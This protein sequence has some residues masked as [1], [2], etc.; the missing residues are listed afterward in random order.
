MIVISDKFRVVVLNKQGNEER[1][2]LRINENDITTNTYI[3]I[4][5]INIDDKLKRL[6]NIYQFFAQKLPCS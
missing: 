6:I 2:K 1:Y 4:L 3:K 5:G